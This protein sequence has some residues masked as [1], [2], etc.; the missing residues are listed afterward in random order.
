MFLMRVFLGFIAGLLILPLF[1]YAYFAW[2]HP[3]VAVGDNP[4]PFEARIVNVPLDARISREAP[5]QAALPLNDANLIAGAL[6]YRQQCASCHGLQGHPSHFG[7]TMY[8]RTPQLWAKHKNSAVVGVSDDPVGDTY[9]KVKN[10]LRLTGM[11]SY[12]TLLSEDQM[13]QVALL[14]SSADKPLPAAAVEFVS[15]PIE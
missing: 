6:V 14:L 15:K 8:P 12:Q 4:F 11:P 1:V 9:W 7:A 2:G 3:P 10:G 5:K 13:W